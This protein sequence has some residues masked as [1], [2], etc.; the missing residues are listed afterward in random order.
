MP[1]AGGTYTYVE[2]GGAENW[3]AYCPAEGK[4]ICSSYADDGF[5]M[6]EFAFK[7]LGFRLP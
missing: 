4:R 2:E 5:A 7:E 6:Y 1:T 3:E